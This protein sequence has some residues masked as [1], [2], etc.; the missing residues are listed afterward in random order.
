MPDA[1]SIVIDH[2][3]AI[4][5]GRTRARI[6]S[7]VRVASCNFV[8][9]YDF[10]VYGYYA[11]YIATS[12]FPVRS[13]FASLMLSLVTFGA[14]YLMRPVGAIILGAYMD[15]KGRKNGLILTL[16]LMAAGTVSIAVT[17][18]YAAIGLIA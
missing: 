5:A 11:S 8:E 13:P 16:G 1:Q 17:P 2:A 12:F 10:I 3:M 18:S 6:G 7:I 4:D 15:R 9:A 14:G